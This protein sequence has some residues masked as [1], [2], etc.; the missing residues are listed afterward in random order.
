MEIADSEG[1]LDM[2][3]IRK[4]PGLMAML[5]H[6]WERTIIPWQAHSYWPTLAHFI[7]GA[8]NADNEVGEGASELEVAA[9]I[10]SFAATAEKSG[11]EPDW[12]SCVS[13]AISAGPSCSSY[14]CIL[15]RREI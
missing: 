10:A 8:L 6:G 2:A 9:S 11:E 15:T 14:A 12:E 7:Q 5:E 13:A 4:D 3:K 1:C